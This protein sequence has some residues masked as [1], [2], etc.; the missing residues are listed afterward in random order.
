MSEI[1]QEGKAAEGRQGILHPPEQ[2][3]GDLERLRRDLEVHRHAHAARLAE[4]LLQHTHLPGELAIRAR[5]HG[6]DHGVGHDLLEDAALQR[7]LELLVVLGHAQ[8]RE[9]HR[10]TEIRELD[11]GLPQLVARVLHRLLGGEGEHIHR[12]PRR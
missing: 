6:A 7:H 11:L 4:D 5:H 9:E 12:H 1:L 2:R 10:R 8:R 3:P